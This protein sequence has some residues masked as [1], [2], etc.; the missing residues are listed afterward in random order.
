MSDRSDIDEKKEVTR[1]S[2]PQQPPPELSEL[3]PGQ[4]QQQPESSIIQHPSPERKPSKL[5]LLEKDNDD[6]EK[7]DVRS[8]DRPGL[9]TQLSNHEIGLEWSVNQFGHQSDGFRD[10]LDGFN[11]FRFNCGMFVNNGHV[12]FFIIMLIA[13]NAIMMGIGTFKFVKED[14]QLDYIFELVDLG[15]LIIFSVELLL[16]FIY[17]GWRIILDGWLLFDLIIIVTSWCFSSVQIIRAFRIF[18]ALRL[19]TRIKIMKNLVLGRFHSHDFLVD[20]VP[21]MRV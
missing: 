17:H 11:Q 20:G 2:T 10:C 21:L 5:E 7:A 12:Q 14:E 4:Q 16:Q 1:P 9:D 3:S 8:L 18:R 6:D 13:I 15:F 19:V